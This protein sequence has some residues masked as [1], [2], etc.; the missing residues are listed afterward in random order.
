[1]N[2]K[3]PLLSL[4]TATAIMTTGVCKDLPIVDNPHIEKRLPSVKQIIF[5]KD[6]DSSIFE[7]A[8]PRFHLDLLNFINGPEQFKACAV[9]RGAGKSTLL[10]KI[11]V[12]NR[13]YFEHE[14]YTLIVS[15][16]E[17][18]AKRFLKD[19]KGLI[20]KMQAKGYSISK[21][22]TWTDTSIEVIINKGKK[23]KDGK[24]LEQLSAID[25]FGAGQDPRGYTHDNNRPTLIIAD[26]LESKVGQ[27]AIGNK[28]NRKKLKN[29]FY[30]DLIP[31]MHPIRGQIIIIGTIL[32]EDSILNNIIMEKNDDDKTNDSEWHT[33]SIPIMEGGKAAWKSRFPIAKIKKLKIRLERL[34]MANHFY[35]EYMCKAMSP[36]KQLFKREMFKYFSHVEY[37]KK[38]E[39]TITL[40]NAKEKGIIK[41]KKPLNIVLED[42]S[43]IS[44]LDCYIYTTMD[45]ATG[46]GADRTAIV[47]FAVAP[48]ND[49]YIL[50]IS[51]GHWSPF[52]KSLQCI[53][54]QSTFNSIKYGI[55]KGGFQNDFLYTLDVA[56]KESGINIP[57]CPL[58]HMKRAKNLRISNLHPLFMTER[59]HFNKSI[60]T[61]TELEGEL[62]AFD[63]AVD[64]KF[65]D[66]M[67]ALA[68][69]L[70]FIQGRTFDDDDDDF[71][72]DEFEDDDE[73]MA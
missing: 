66:I 38:I 48:T 57:V 40:Q 10:N 9:F 58:S 69:L 36:D 23:D 19:I 2:I 32:H 3:K 68:Y 45:L 1:M 61:T 52:E 18:K 46:D 7:N 34:G 51:A 17:K 70:D 5:A 15:E 8:T 21:G 47:T 44:L 26:D 37:D 59:I 14:P 35:Q 4:I 12:L 67:D 31:S 29:W 30:S 22:K 63:P 24:S 39:P 28:E 53:R 49:I 62:L 33:K 6:I 60:S 56:I 13:I 42:G 11:L 50:D 41:T 72:E 20:L 27:Y 55:E 71:E 25:V 64:S 16:S 54:I 43:K 73:R 65:D